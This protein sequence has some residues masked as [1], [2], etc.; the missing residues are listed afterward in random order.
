VALADDRPVGIHAFPQWSE[1]EPHPSLELTEQTGLTPWLGKLLLRTAADELREQP[2][3]A[4]TLAV[5]LTPTQSAAADLVATVLAVLKESGLCPERLRIA[6]PT[7]EVCHDREA[8]VNLSRI[9]AAGVRT[10]I[11]DFDGGAAE[12][13]QLADLPVDE[14]WLGERLV[15][16]VKR[17]D[18][19]TLTADAVRGLVELVHRTGA[20]VGVGDIRD[21]AEANWW[22]RTGADLA[23]GRLYCPAGA[24]TDIADL[25][26]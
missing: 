4:L 25:F 19:A 22:R 18:K 12:L 3:A 6:M 17:P 13:V 2:S 1:D 15:R 5:N 20:T 7:T 24:Q 23:A 10:A 14:V 16:Q 9:A 8:A 26:G 21:R 11:H